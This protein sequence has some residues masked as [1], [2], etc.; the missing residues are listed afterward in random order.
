MMLALRQFW[1][2]AVALLLL[3]G[4]GYFAYQAGYDASEA[5]WLEKERQRTEGEAKAKAAQ[6]AKQDTLAAQLLQR[7]H[8]INE[9]NRSLH[10]ALSKTTTGRQCL[11]AGTVSLLNAG[12][13]LRLPAHQP[14]S[15][16]ESASGTPTDSND[17]GSTDTQI[18]GWIADAQQQYA[19]C[20]GRLNDLIEATDWS[21]G[22]AR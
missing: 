11:S 1:P 17:A 20:A 19:V 13:G 3:A 12:T 4:L 15:A 7:E 6:T 5:A 16:P 10:N 18:A 22:H 14:G 8:T 9:L 21:V 2:A